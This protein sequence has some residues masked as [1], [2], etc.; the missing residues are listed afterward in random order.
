MFTRST[1]DEVAYKKYRAVFRK[2]ARKAE[3]LYYRHIFNTKANS[4]KKLRENLNTVCSFRKKSTSKNNVSQLCGGSRTVIAPQKICNE[5]N[6]YFSTTD[7][8]LMEELN[9]S[10]PDVTDTDFTEFCG[11]PTNTSMFVTPVGPEELQRFVNSLTNNKSPGM[12]NIG[13][14]L[15]KL[16]F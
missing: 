10:H 16:V 12:D 2:A 8:V 15:V 5:F 6:N 3:N 14:R 13:P 1:S 9:K 7:N 4:M 11:K